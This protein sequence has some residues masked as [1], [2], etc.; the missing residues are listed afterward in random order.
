MTSLGAAQKSVLATPVQNAA[1]KKVAAAGW[2]IT[3]CLHFS[4]RGKG[5]K[6]GFK[7]TPVLN[8]AEGNGEA[9]VLSLHIPDLPA[10]CQNAAGFEQNTS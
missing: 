6:S 10:C 3:P 4:G 8:G 2:E 9:A 1:S 7:S 5:K